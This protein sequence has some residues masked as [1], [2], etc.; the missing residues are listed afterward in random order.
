MESKGT[1][2]QCASNYMKE[3]N[4]SLLSQ[5]LEKVSI[6][7]DSARIVNHANILVKLGQKVFP[8]RFLIK[9]FYS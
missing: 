3:N 1:I 5:L 2:L 4:L 8:N 6:K 9:G 7:I